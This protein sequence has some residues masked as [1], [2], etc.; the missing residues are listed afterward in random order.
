MDEDII[1][2]MGK[3]HSGRAEA[4]SGVGKIFGGDVLLP[5]F[6]AGGSVKQANVIFEAGRTGFKFV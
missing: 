1:T 4:A 2:I 6:G 3:F 5:D